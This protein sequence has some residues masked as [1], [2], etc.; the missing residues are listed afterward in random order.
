MPDTDFARWQNRTGLIRAV[1]AA[2]ILGIS[3]Q[4]ATDLREGRKPLTSR[5]LRRLMDLL[6]EHPELIERD[7]I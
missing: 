3:R 4:H 2:R 1:D 5:P 6:A 7:R